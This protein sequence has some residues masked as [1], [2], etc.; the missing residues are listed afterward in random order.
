MR[1]KRKSLFSS[2]RAVAAK[3]RRSETSAEERERDRISKKNQRA[4]EPEEQSSFHREK[5]QTHMAETRDNDF[6]SR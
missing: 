2:K 5:D 6:F 3:K 4:N 1:G